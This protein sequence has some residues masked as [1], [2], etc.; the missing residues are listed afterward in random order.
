[1]YHC[2][3][4]KHDFVAWSLVLLILLTYTDQLIYHLRNYFRLWLGRFRLSACNAPTC[5]FFTF[6]Y[7]DFR[8]HA[9]HT[10]LC[11]QV[12]GF[13]AKLCY[14]DTGRRLKGQFGLLLI[15]WFCFANLATL[16]STEMYNTYSEIDKNTNSD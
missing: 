4:I 1:M 7:A 3:R 15:S 13:P 9:L 14:F 10:R 8:K 5:F 16:R 11:C 2:I 6:H 12:P